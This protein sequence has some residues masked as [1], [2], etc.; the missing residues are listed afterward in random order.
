M[1]P[2]GIIP[3]SYVS[4]FLTHIS[5]KDQRYSNVFML[6][7]IQNIYIIFILKF[8][9]ED[10]MKLITRTKDIKYNSLKMRLASNIT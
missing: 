3:F 6:N 2:L 10:Y 5:R 7:F 8:T 9:N 1:F 4:N